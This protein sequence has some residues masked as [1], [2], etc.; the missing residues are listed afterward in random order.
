MVALAHRFRGKPSRPKSHRGRGVPPA[1][2]RI[3]RPG[4][5]RLPK[6][7]ASWPAGPP[8][9]LPK[10]QPK[11]KT[12]PFS[13]ATGFRRSSRRARSFRVRYSRR[14]LAMYSRESN[15]GRRIFRIWIVSSGST[16]GPSI[17]P[18]S[19]LR[20]SRKPGESQVTKIVRETPRLPGHPRRLLSSPRRRQP[21]TARRFAVLDQF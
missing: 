6:A 4:H 2:G 5:L 9:T 11:T 15:L 19:R 18:Q 17:E 21:W 12:S 20:I 10:T 13:T 16:P 7:R 14:F 8:K 3:F 1:S